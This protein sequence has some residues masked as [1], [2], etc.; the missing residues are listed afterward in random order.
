MV[1]GQATQHDDDP[2]MRETLDFLQCWH[3]G[4]HDDDE[5]DDAGGDKR[6]Q[7]EKHFDAFK[8]MW[9]S[10]FTGPPTHKSPDLGLGFMG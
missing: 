3:H 1:P 10:S 9:N 6:G 5:A 8:D 4:R 2:L 7:F